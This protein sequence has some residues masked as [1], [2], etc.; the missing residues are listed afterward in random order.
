[1]NIW[2]ASVAL[3]ILHPFWWVFFPKSYERAKEAMRRSGEEERKAKD[4]QGQGV[5]DADVEMAEGAEGEV[6]REAGEETPTQ[7][8]PVVSGAS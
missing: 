7:P 6:R 8:K 5:A 4:V 1:M 3:A 2:N